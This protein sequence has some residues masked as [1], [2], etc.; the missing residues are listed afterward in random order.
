MTIKP[1]AY[2]LVFT[3]SVA[4]FEDVDQEDYSVLQAIL[5]GALEDASRQQRLLCRVTRFD[6]RPIRS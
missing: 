3:A 5:E 6:L 4:S 2:E 1:Y